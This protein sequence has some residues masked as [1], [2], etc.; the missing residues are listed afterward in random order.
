MILW[1]IGNSGSTLYASGETH[2]FLYSDINGETSLSQK[3]GYYFDADGQKQGETVGN[4]MRD[5][6]TINCT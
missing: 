3:E 2:I 6:N 4:F 1:T 5:P